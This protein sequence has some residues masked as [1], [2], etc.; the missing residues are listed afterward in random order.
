MELNPLFITGVA[1]RLNPGKKAG[2]LECVIACF[3][4]DCVLVAEVRDGHLALSVDKAHAF[5]VFG[6]ILPQISKLGK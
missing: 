5:A 4:K 6:K 1:E 3:E 2:N